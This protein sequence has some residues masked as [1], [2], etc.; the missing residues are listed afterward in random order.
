MSNVPN[1]SSTSSWQAS[2]MSIEADALKVRRS[3]NDEIQQVQA[4]RQEARAAAARL[5]EAKRRLDAPRN[6]GSENEAA[7]A[8]L[9]ATV[10]Q[11]EQQ[12]GEAIAAYEKA[13]KAFHKQR[14][15]LRQQQDALTQRRDSLMREI[16]QRARQAYSDL[17]G[18]GVP[19]PVASALDGRCAACGQDLTS[20]TVREPWL[21]PACHRLVIAPST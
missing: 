6:R 4:K 17:L 18:H 3:E 16:P 19:D 13:L 10:A 14:A 11:A 12:Q 15:N 5:A 9:R 8:S 2:L 20:D 21:C 7:L 1:A